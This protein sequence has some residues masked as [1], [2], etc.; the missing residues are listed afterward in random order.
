MHYTTT[1]ESRE[2]RYDVTKQD[3]DIS[4]MAFRSKSE[5]LDVWMGFERWMS[6][7]LDLQNDRSQ[8]A[9]EFGLLGAVAVYLQVLYR[10]DVVSGPTFFYAI[11]FTLAQ[12]ALPNEVFITKMRKV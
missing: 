5:I 12:V 7:D 10:N 8:P 9:A 1:V 3:F 11:C 2:S 4:E 6:H